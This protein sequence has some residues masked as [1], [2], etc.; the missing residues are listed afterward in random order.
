MDAIC[1]R[2][3]GRWAARTDVVLSD[4]RRMLISTSQRC[5]PRGLSTAVWVYAGKAAGLNPGECLAAKV[6]ISSHPARITRR[7]VEQQ[8]ATALEALRKFGWP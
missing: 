4:G 8:H 5:I 2:E 1:Y 7:R 6:L 3:A